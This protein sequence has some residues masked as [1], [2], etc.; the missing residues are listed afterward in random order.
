MHDC[1]YGR[2]APKTNADFWRAK[3]QSNVDRDH[4]NINDLEA[5]GWQVLVVWECWTKP[6]MISNLPDRLTHFLGS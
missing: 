4:R 5:A 6:Q 3:R 2:V 1:P